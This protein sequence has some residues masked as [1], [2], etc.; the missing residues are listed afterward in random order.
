MICDK[1]D[2]LKQWEQNSQDLITF[3]EDR[4]GHD[5]RYSIDSSKAK[6]Q[7]GWGPKVNFDEGLD[8]TID[9]YFKKFGSKEQSDYICGMKQTTL[10]IQ[11]EIFGK[12]LSMS[13]S[14]MVQTK[15]FLKLVNDAIDNG[16]AFRY[17]NVT[18]TLIQIPFKILSECLI[19]TEN[20]VMTFSDQVLAKVGEVKQS[21]LNK[22][23]DRLPGW[24]QKGT[25]VFPFFFLFVFIYK[26]ITMSKIVITQEQLENLK[27]TLSE[28]KGI[29]KEDKDGNYMA[30]QQL[31]TIG[32]LA[33]QMWEIMED[34]EQLDDWMESKIAQAEQ[35]I[36]SVVKAYMYDEVVDGMKGMETL[37]YND[38]VIGK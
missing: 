9:F 35:S 34:D 30:K 5:F 37:N 3:V 19:T 31:F 36:T 23:V 2:N 28:N 10:I 17:F 1:I 29:V 21:L 18:D 12:I 20:E 32:T 4:K 27:K 7:I 11:H 6:Q 8:R 26:T 13:F 15:L 16:K 14:D 24:A 22:V 38:I 25:L 33:L